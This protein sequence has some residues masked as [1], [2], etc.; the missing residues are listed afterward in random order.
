M[1][2]EKAPKTAHSYPATYKEALSAEQRAV[3]LVAQHVA[4][5]DAEQTPE[6]LTILHAIEKCVPPGL[7]E[8]FKSTPEKQKTY[9]VT[10]IADDIN[11]GL[12]YVKYSAQQGPYQDQVRLRILTGPDGWLNPIDR[13]TYRGVRFRKVAE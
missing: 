10:G 9:L 7:Y 4:N 2:H 11:T 5:R 8:H 1:S 6:T 13:P 12:C 3:E